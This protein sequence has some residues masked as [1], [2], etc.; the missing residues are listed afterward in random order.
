MPSE[1]GMEVRKPCWGKHAWFKLKEEKGKAMV[2]EVELRKVS[3]LG[4][5]K[6]CKQTG[7][8][9]GNHKHVIS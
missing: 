1:S 4:T 8:T 7:E 6:T 9:S 2:S 5:V 3:W